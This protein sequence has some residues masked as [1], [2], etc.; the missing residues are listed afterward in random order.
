L[1]AL[2]FCKQDVHFRFLHLI[3]VT[4]VD[5]KLVSLLER[6]SHVAEVLHILG[7]LV[8][9]KDWV[10]G[11]LFV[12][13]LL[14]CLHKAFEF[15]KTLPEAFAKNWACGSNYTFSTGICIFLLSF[16]RSNLTSSALSP[17]HPESWLIHLDLERRLNAFSPCSC[18]LPDSMIHQVEGYALLPPFVLVK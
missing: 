3:H 12:E 4:E 15:A 14:F 8:E 17:L 9:D 10:F 1:V 7:E 6:Y 2:K 18:V 5:E 13:L 16:L 11:S